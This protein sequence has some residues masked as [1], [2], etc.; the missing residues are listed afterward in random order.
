MR[1]IDLDEIRPTILPQID[2][3][4][5]AKREVLAEHDPEQRRALLD[6][7]RT[8]WTAV[9]DAFEAYSN[10]K[11]WYVECSNPGAGNDIDHYRP[12]GGVAQDRTHPGYYWLA[13][14][15]RNL[16]LSCQR[17]NRLRKNPETGETGG[18]GDNFPLVNPEWRAHMPEH[19]LSLEVPAIVDPTDPDD[20]SL[21]TFGRNGEVELV[22]ERKDEPVAE[23]KLKASQRHLHLNWPKFRDAR[24]EL[25]NQIERFV[26]RGE[27]LAPEEF[28]DLAPEEFED[29]APEQIDELNDVPR[30]F[31]DI[32]VDLANW[33]RPREDYSMAA[34]AYVQMFRD[35]WWVRD[36][37]LPLT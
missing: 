1:F 16:R 17:A 8:R 19:D 23:A 27:D 10:G 3:L 6:R 30:A 29:L 26:H 20:V 11:C 14:E 13:F 37:V 7:Y 31:L 18:K 35:R 2:E 28:E 33:T 9:R 22:P 15:W 34:L 21:L 32:C 12:K 4:E 5:E 24:V 25:Y 36:I